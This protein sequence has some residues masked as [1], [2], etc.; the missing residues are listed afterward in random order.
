MRTYIHT[1]IHTYIC[2]Y[3][4]SGNFRVKNNS[5]ENFFALI[6]FRGWVHPWNF[7]NRSKVLIMETYTRECCV[8]GYHVYWR[9]WSSA[10]GE[11]FHCER[12]PTNSQD[13]Y[14]VAVKKDETVIGHLPQKVSRVCS[15]FL[16]RGGTVYCRVSGSRRYSS[17]LPQGGLEIPCEVIFT[18]K[19]GEI[20]KLK[21]SLKSWGCGH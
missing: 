9:I 20:K 7:F 1:Y 2:T 8:R 5:R 11:V 14:A 3:R 18:A 17:D 21:R 10:V 13:R 16:R 15:L 12:E 6:N 4:R 19:A